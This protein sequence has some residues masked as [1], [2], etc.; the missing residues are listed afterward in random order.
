MKDIIIIGDGLGVRTFPAKAMDLN[1]IGTDVSKY[2]VTNCNSYIKDCFIQDDI[3]NTTIKEKAKLVVIYDVL[4]HINYE[5]IDTAIKNLK[6]ISLKHILISV[7][8]IGDPNLEADPTHIIKETKEWWIKK[9][10]SHGIKIIPTPEY[11]NYKEQIIIGEVN[12]N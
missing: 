1:V 10:E 6:S 11:F 5:E 4:E 7:P 9:I 12:D 2:A 3:L 8:T